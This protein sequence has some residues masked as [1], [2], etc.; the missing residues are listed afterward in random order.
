MRRAKP[1]K[2]TQRQSAPSA[3]IDDVAR[4]ILTTRAYPVRATHV[5]TVLASAEQTIREMQRFVDARPRD[6][7]ACHA[8]HSEQRALRRQVDHLLAAHV[9]LQQGSRTA[10]R[11]SHDRSA[12]KIY[13]QAADHLRRSVD[14]LVCRTQ[15]ARRVFSRWERASITE[16]TDQPGYRRKAATV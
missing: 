7:P 15:Q 16:R 4:D 1:R 8:V 3:K 6:V 11:S 5:V 9:R 12:D 14:D 13:D 10:I 2:A